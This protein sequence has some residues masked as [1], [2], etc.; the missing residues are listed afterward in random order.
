MNPGHAA[1]GS[2]HAAGSRHAAAPQIRTAAYVKSR[3]V[4]A[5]AGE[6]RG[7]LRVTTTYPSGVSRNIQD[8]ASGAIRSTFSAPDG[9][10]LED[11]SSTGTGA[12]ATTT[13]VDYTVRAW[14]TNKD[15]ACL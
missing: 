1:A 5:L 6:T 12:T 9:A 8:L 14:W 11:D 4:A 3:A 10:I 13:I 7:T 15:D 2:G